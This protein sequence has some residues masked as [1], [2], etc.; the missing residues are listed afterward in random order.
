MVHRLSYW[1]ES[2]VVRIENRRMMKTPHGNLI[3]AVE[4]AP[5]NYKSR[6]RPGSL[7][8]RI[9]ALQEDNERTLAASPYGIGTLLSSSALLVAAA[10]ASKR[11]QADPVCTSLKIHV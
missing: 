11:S 2:E 3:P 8:A 5:N 1:F 4:D 10:A 7:E 6:P 9:Q